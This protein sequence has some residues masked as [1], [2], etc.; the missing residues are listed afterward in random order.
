MRSGEWVTQKRQTPGRICFYRGE[1]VSTDFGILNHNF[2]ENKLLLN[3]FKL[4]T[5]RGDFEVCE[6]FGGTWDVSTTDSQEL[7]LH[8]PEFFFLLFFFPSGFS[9]LPCLQYR[10]EPNQESHA[11]VLHAPGAQ[12]TVA[13]I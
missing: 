6:Q 2:P 3:P 5:P 4:R 12:D 7:K 11:R 1:I 13:Y 8:T 10:S 9:S